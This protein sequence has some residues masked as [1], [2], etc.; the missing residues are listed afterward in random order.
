MHPVYSCRHKKLRLIQSKF[1]VTCL[2]DTKTHPPH[3]PAELISTF[4]LAFINT[5]CMEAFTWYLNWQLNYLFKFSDMTNQ[6]F[7]PIT[8]FLSDKIILSLLDSI[9]DL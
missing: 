4:L 8:I 2:S 3:L 5:A 1:R 9:I 7:Y 6:G